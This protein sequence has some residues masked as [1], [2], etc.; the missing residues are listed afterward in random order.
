MAGINAVLKLRGEEPFVLGRDEAYIGVLIDDLVFKG[1]NEPY[2]IMTS[3]AEYRLLLRQ[4]NAD[5]RLTEKSYKIGLATKERMDKYLAKKELIENEI[6]RLK[7]TKIKAEVINPLLEELGSSPVDKS[8]A[9][10]EL[11]RRPEISYDKLAA[12]DETRPSLPRR[13]T[14]QAEV[15]IKYEG[16]I[17]K[18]LERVEKFKRMENKRIPD[19]IDYLSIDGLRIEAR[20]KLD[21]LR[22]ESLGQA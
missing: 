15:R 2:R 20:Q 18:Q 4:D 10:A 21:K 9:L 13:M 8:V 17:G 6:E 14:A 7:T 22:P 3:R 11:M 16:Y 12:V 5:E 1:T 19:D